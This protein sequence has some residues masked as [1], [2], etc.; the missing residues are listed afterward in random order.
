MEAAAKNGDVYAGAI[1]GAMDTDRARV[2]VEVDSLRQG[3]VETDGGDD[4]N[5]GKE[6]FGVLQCGK[7]SF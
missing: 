1:D 7:K 3:N 5:K 4:D 6:T 2:K